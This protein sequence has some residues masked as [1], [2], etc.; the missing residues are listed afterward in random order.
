MRYLAFILIVALVGCS[1]DN[2]PSEYNYTER[3]VDVHGLTLEPSANMKVSFEEVSSIYE[4]TMAC[5][6][7]TAP[8]PVVE[9][10]SFSTYYLG[11]DWGLYHWG[12]YV[13]VNTDEKDQYAGFPERSRDTDTQVLKHEF[14]HHILN[15]NGLPYHDG[16]SSDL[17]K[18]CG[19]GVDV[20]N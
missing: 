18:L 20:H 14:I 2:P 6:G 11:S 13:F 4:G 5:L 3:Q 19:H 15:E 17:F 16:E 9:F 12:G 10:K 7:L 8:G 1:A